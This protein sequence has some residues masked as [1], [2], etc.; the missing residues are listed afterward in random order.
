MGYIELFEVVDDNRE[1]FASEV[2]TGGDLYDFALEL[3][4]EEMD[5]EDLHEVIK[6]IESYDYTVY[7]IE[8]SYPNYFEGEDN[9]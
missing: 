7:N 5:G 9:E 1:R 4:D 2:M 8:K 6:V 3:T